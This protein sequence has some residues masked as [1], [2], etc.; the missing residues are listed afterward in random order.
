LAA[1][2]AIDKEH[3]SQ[4]VK[5]IASKEEIASTQESIA[6]KKVSTNVTKGLTAA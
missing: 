2:A 4:E 6:G 1:A 3:L 5:N